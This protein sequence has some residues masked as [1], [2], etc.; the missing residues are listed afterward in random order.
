MLCPKQNADKLLL[1]SAVRTGS[2]VRLGGPRGR[3][4]REGRTDEHKLVDERRTNP[5]R[6]NQRD[7][8]SG[9]FKG[10]TICRFFLDLRDVDRKSTAV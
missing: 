10:L 1:G 6:C 8:V 3:V 2:G 7:W 9:H 5:G 4:L